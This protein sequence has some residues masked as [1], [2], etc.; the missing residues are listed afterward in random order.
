MRQIKITLLMGIFLLPL[1][2]GMSFGQA[3]SQAEGQLALELTHY[4]QA[5]QAFE[6]AQK[7][8]GLAK[9]ATYTSDIAEYYE[10]ALKNYKLALSE[11]GRSEGDSEQLSQSKKYERQEI[12]DES[13]E[14]IEVCE[15]KYQAASSGSD[16]EQLKHQASRK[17]ITGFKH[18]TSGEK[19][20]A[21][22]DWDDAIRL[23]KKA[24]GVTKEEVE[25]EVIQSKIKE[26]EHYI[27]KY[28]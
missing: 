6:Q 1:A 14:K 22:R 15:E 2:S 7:A 8:E 27:E 17:V 10:T 25:V 28:L 13:R 23:Y 18:A 5:Q 12:I 11:A 3:L 24:L 26:V 20:D 16:L 9:I 19:A 21:K 4:E